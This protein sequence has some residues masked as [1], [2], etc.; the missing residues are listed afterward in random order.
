[1]KK[2]F[3]FTL[4]HL[5][6]ACTMLNTKATFIIDGNL[7]ELRSRDI[8]YMDGDGIHSKLIG[9][10]NIDALWNLSIYCDKINGF[11]YLG[12]KLSTKS[13][14]QQYN[15]SFTMNLEFWHPSSNDTESVRIHV[16]DKYDIDEC[17]FLIKSIL[18]NIN[19]YGV[20]S[21]TLHEIE[22]IAVS[23]DIWSCFSD[24]EEKTIQ[25]WTCD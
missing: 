12:A 14:Y 4:E 23:H 18:K 2:V 9:T 17:E 25:L 16:N 1:M 19:K 3:T 8:W 7:E 13:S 15:I 6:K 11:Y 10:I 21:V 5:V 22:F 24:I 20:V